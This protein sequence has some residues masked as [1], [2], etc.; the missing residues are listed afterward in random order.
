MTINSTDDK[1]NF[2][3][4]RNDK[5]SILVT[6]NNVDVSKNNYKEETGTIIKVN[7]KKITLKFGE[8]KI[9]CSKFRAIFFL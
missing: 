6:E 9:I 5:E 3:T 2:C 4:K 1:F 8:N 7:R